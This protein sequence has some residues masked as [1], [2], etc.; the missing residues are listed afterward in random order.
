M[1]DVDMLDCR[2]NPLP[3]HNFPASAPHGSAW[4]KPITRSVEDVSNCLS[5]LAH[6]GKREV[7]GLIT[8]CHNYMG[9]NYVGD[10]YIGRNYIGRRAARADRRLP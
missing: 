5:S 1:F 2:H 6:G 10:N 4:P 7:G 8:D 9:H 3:P